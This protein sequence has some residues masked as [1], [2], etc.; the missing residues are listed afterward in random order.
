MTDMKKLFYLLSLGIISGMVLMASCGGDGD[1]DLTE[2]QK[3]AQLLAGTWTHQTTS[4][5][6][7]G[8]SP[9]I[10]DQL[11]LT[12]NVDGNYNA[13]S[14]SSSGAPDF[15]ITSGTSKWAFSG[16][17]TTSLIL[18]DVSPVT[19]LTINSLTANALTVS[20]TFVSGGARVASLEGNYRV[21]LTK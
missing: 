8:V 21:D 12:F 10:L 6:P 15:F 1:G 4:Q 2:Q 9:D 17:S 18:T 16:T 14:F 13:T 3:Q 5:S 20:F 19:D 11:I 7:P